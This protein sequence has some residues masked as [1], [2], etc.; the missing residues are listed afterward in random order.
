MA[1]V[2]TSTELTRWEGPR[3]IMSISE[4]VDL[5]K[6]VQQAQRDLLSKD[7]DWGNI[8][9]AA[10]PMLFQPGAEKLLQLFGLGFVLELAQQDVDTNGELQ[11]VTYRCLVFRPEVGQRVG[12]VVA[13]CD[14]HAGYDESRFYESEA[15]R[16][17]REKANA[18]KYK[19]AAKK[20]TGDYRADVHSLVMMA[21][22][23]ALVGAAR[24]ATASSGLF[25]QDLED[26]AAAETV[27]HSAH[28]V[29]KT[30]SELTMKLTKVQR[31]SL[32]AWSGQEK[33]TTKIAELT[34]EQCCRVLVAI[35]II[36]TQPEPAP[37]ETAAMDTESGEPFE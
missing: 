25:T 16:N 32:V 31:Q 3:A 24:H 10:K 19:R 28:A 5:Q 9:G 26:Q 20:L 15:E 12:T 17:A 18:A 33:L 34:M 29:R 8:P 37:E 23:R 36:S 30:L 11:G 14:G 13:S 4:A 27:D 7:E 2:T 22:K 21:Q 1:E 6:L 35:G